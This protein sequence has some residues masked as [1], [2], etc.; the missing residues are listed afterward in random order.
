MVPKPTLL[1]YGRT[2]EICEALKNLSRSRLSPHGVM[3]NCEKD[4][5][6]LG[7][8]KAVNESN[9]CELV[10]ADS[11]GMEQALRK[12]E[13][14]QAV[15][16]L[17]AEEISLQS[18][19]MSLVR[20]KIQSDPTLRKESPKRV[21]D[22]IRAEWRYSSQTACQADEITSL[23]IEEETVPFVSVECLK[24]QPAISL[25]F[26]HPRIRLKDPKAYLAT[27]MLKN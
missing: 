19:T 11:L 12:E 21:Y 20:E 10:T 25:K 27:T 24:T 17:F 5:K 13:S 16:N 6:E 22:R 23:T 26:G 3:R 1:S 9:E 7:T 18:V 15:Q 14:L 4:D 8:R 2:W